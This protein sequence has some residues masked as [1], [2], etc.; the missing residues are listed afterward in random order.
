[1]MT[2]QGTGSTG[3][4][5]EG[6]SSR[7]RVPA[8]RLA[9]RLARR[10]AGQPARPPGR[11]AALAFGRMATLA[12]G[13]MAA[14]AAA[15][16]LPT[17]ALGAAPS[18]LFEDAGTEEVLEAL[19]EECFEAGMIAEPVAD[20]LVCSTT[21]TGDEELG[22]M[23]VV[24]VYGGRARHQ[25]RFALAERAGGI[26]V[27]AYPSIEIEEPGGNLL[28]QEI[29]SDEYSA[30][31]QAVL[32]DTAETLSEAP[33]PDSRPWAAH[34]AT[35]DEWRLDAHLRAVAYCDAGLEDLTPEELD[36][37]LAMASFQPFGKGLRDRCEELYEE[38][39]RWGLARGIDEPTVEA[40]AEYQAALPPEERVCSG[41]LALGSTCR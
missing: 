25:I 33:G 15:A 28:E 17:V 14:L 16:A 1:M 40:Y 29:T 37:Q 38:I 13:R 2:E 36:R 10:W 4:E 22:G 34:Y 11:T 26:R 18:I 9:G 41:R 3:R 5:Y 31:V 20:Q 30:R 7:S 8:C 35:Q 39:F 27:W 19:Y 6:S 32:T 12:L 23:S 21:L 24:N